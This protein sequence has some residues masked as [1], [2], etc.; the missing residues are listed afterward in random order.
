MLSIS[1]CSQFYPSVGKTSPCGGNIHQ[2]TTKYTDNRI[3]PTDIQ[4]CD[5][6]MESFKELGQR[7]KFELTIIEDRII[8]VITPMSSEGQRPSQETK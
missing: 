1:N 7:P 6:H 4:V 5:S 2:L 3:P 8:G